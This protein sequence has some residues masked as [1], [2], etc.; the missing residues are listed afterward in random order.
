MEKE[1][2]EKGGVLEGRKEWRLDM[3]H[4]DSV[5]KCLWKASTDIM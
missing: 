1:G 3:S 5:K 2:G 4:V